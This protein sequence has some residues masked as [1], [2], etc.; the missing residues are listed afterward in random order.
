MSEL[1]NHNINF[2]LAVLLHL[3]MVA[4]PKVQQIK[5]VYNRGTFESWDPDLSIERWLELLNE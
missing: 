5:Q 1:N 3:D 4:P 2:F